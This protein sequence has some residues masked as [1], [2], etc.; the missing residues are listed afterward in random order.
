MPGMPA[1]RHPWP[2][3]AA[4]ALDAA[5]ISMAAYHVL[6]WL[7]RR[8]PR[9]GGVREA[10]AATGLHVGE[11][12]RAMGA[13]SARGVLAAD[14][15]GVRLAPTYA[16]GLLEA[17]QRMGVDRAL[18]REAVAVAADREVAEQVVLRVCW[19]P[20][21]PTPPRAPSSLTSSVPGAPGPSRSGGPAAPAA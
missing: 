18:R 7:V 5:L 8:H 1:P 19:A 20:P 4:R 11:V 3:A 10:V 9:P 16:P 2:P 17:W 15:A 12:A 21:A 14:A 13:L 6:D